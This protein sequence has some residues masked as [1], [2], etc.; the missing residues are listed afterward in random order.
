MPRN[1]LELDSNEMA[2][3]VESADDST[4]RAISLA[5]CKWAVDREL[6]DDPVVQSALA[7]LEGGNYGD[8]RFLA[9]LQDH[10]NKLDLIYFDARDAAQDFFPLFVKARVASAVL[11]ALDADPFRAVTHCLYELCESLGTDFRF[12]PRSIAC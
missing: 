9:S 10:V 5:A 8:P 6:S 12:R 11:F 2:S 4:K 3:Q 7:R 1:V